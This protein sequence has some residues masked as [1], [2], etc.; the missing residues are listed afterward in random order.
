MMALLA[1]T[2]GA[3]GGSDSDSSLRFD[4][5]AANALYEDGQFD[6]ALLAYQR[7]LTSRPD[8][9]QVSYN[10][11]N[12]LNHLGRYD[13]AVV[14]T[15]RG[16]PPQETQLGS[17]TYF[18][19]GN[20]LVALEQY[21]QAYDAYKNAL[22]LK[23]DDEDAKWN[24]ELVL[25]QLRRQQ[26]NQQGGQGPGQTPQSQ[27]NQGPTQQ[28]QSQGQ[29]QPQQGEPGQPQPGQPGQGQQQGD[30]SQQQQ[31]AE[32][33]RTLTEALKGLD[34]ELSYEDAIKILDLLRRTQ[35]TQQARP[36]PP[37]APAGPDY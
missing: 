26:P 22:L 32:A 6:K 7:L 2:L 29:P 14:E 12:T 36:S 33:Q 11:G 30:P 17:M 8:V 20:H 4:V 9:P 18:A 13:R 10:A 35:E 34:K 27:G 23:P 15:Q 25:A 16:L 28:G 19:L 5:K 24:L 21:E 37:G 1:L 3:C 31:A